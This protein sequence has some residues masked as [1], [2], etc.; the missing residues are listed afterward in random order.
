MWKRAFLFSS[1]WPSKS[2]PYNQIL[3]LTLIQKIDF[4]WTSGKVQE[5]L[6]LFVS[7]V[8]PCIPDWPGTLDPPALCLL[9]QSLKCWDFKLVLSFLYSL[10]LYVF[11]CLYPKL[12]LSKNNFLYYIFLLCF[13]FA[14]VSVGTVFYYWLEGLTNLEFQHL[15]TLKLGED[16]NSGPCTY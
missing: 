2:I 7:M 16:L 14:D 1:F 11:V 10:S 12:L 4:A 5:F 6:Y 3:Q 15:K 9:P 8:L 13:L